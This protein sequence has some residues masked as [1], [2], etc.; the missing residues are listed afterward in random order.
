MSFAKK[1]CACDPTQNLNSQD[2][3]SGKQDCYIRANALASSTVNSTLAATNSSVPTSYFSLNSSN[4]DRVSPLAINP[5]S[6]EPVAKAALQ[7]KILLVE[8]NLGDM[9]LI[10]E[11]LRDICDPRL[12]FGYALSLNHASTLRE[13]ISFV[14]ES[15][16]DIL[17]LDLSLPDARGLE[18]IEALRE[19]A[20]EVPIVLITG[21]GDLK[22]AIK[23]LSQGVQDYLIKG[24]IDG[25][26]LVRSVV[27]AVERARYERERRELEQKFLQTQKLESLGLMAGG[28]AHDFN[29]LLMGVLSN[30]TMALDQV[31]KNT[32]LQT[33][34][35]R[36]LNAG[37]RAAELVQQLLAYCGQEPIELDNVS[38]NSLVEEIDDLLENVISP[39][40]TIHYELS[41]SPLFVRGDVTQFRQV[42]MNLVTN[43]SDALEGGAGVINIST[44]QICLQGGILTDEFSGETLP[45]GNYCILEVA[46]TGKGMDLQTAKRIFDPFFT[47]KSTGRGLGLAAVLGIVRAHKG[48]LQVESALGLGSTFRIYLPLCA[49]DEQQ[50]TLSGSFPSQSEVATE[51]MILVVD[52]EETVLEIVKDTLEQS[53]FCVIS[54]TNGRDGLSIFE[55]HC[56]VISAVLLD[57]TMPHIR[58]EDVMCRMRSIRDDVPIILSSGYGEREALAKIAKDGFASFIQKPYLPK[59]LVKRIN[60]VCEKRLAVN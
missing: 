43:A 46:D 18:G 28:I 60:E 52:D 57:M 13:A 4:Q 38:I 24:Q 54:A 20:P 23:T 39:K 8:D 40:A 9:V 29:N 53:G 21:D 51:G 33:K 22:L 42:L 55:A 2:P 31:E 27:Y 41:S 44:N 15:K 5:L 25:H 17:L 34:L 10:R 48:M 3:H 47:T 6:G 16:P 30:A 32:P 50:L 49:A 14:Q 12:S 56:N 26:L 59:D 45:P 58:G 1:G 19:I 37:Q 36:I 11:M 35:H 7:I